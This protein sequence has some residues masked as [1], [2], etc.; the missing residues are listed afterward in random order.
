MVSSLFVTIK[1][2]ILSSFSNNHDF[3]YHKYD[4]FELNHLRIS[5][6]IFY[7]TIS[8]RYELHMLISQLSSSD[9]PFSKRMKRMCNKLSNLFLAVLL[10]FPIQSSASF[11]LFVKS[12]QWLIVIVSCWKSYSII[13]CICWEC[14]HRMIRWLTMVIIYKYNRYAG[15]VCCFQ[16]INP[17]MTPLRIIGTN[18]SF[19]LSKNIIW[20]NYASTRYF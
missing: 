20:Y 17:E 2:C 3:D 8:N 10:L 7:Y 19:D 12:T 5:I 15:V 13:I 16:L 18:G 4:C 1:K 14:I 9:N 6:F 11:L